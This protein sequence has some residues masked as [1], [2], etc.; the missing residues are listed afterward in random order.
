[1]N[2]SSILVPET[3]NYS[4]G[5][6]KGLAELVNKNNFKYEILYKSEF[7]FFFR[8]VN[9]QLIIANIYVNIKEFDSIIELI[10]DTLNM[11]LI[12]FPG[13]KIVVGED[14]NSRLAEENSFVDENILEGTILYDLRKSKDLVLDSRG[15]RLLELMK[16][17]GFLLINGR[18]EALF[19][20]VSK[21]K[22]ISEY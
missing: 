19:L 11:I 1:M 13:E 20:N 2:F 4:R 10:K 16:G 7:C 22:Y 17:F 18:T 15:R 3:R 9:V 6:A 5:R 21:Y 12:R 8:L 14:F